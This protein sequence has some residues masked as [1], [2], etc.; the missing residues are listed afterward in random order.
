M[1]HAATNTDWIQAGL[2][3]ACVA[4]GF[5]CLLTGKGSK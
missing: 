2:S 1:S 4:V 3:M 5:I